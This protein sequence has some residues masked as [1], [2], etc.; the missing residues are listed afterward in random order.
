VTCSCLQCIESLRQQ[1]KA[2]NAHPPFAETEFCCSDCE[3]DKESLL[4]MH[5][6]RDLVN[7]C[8]CG[9]IYGKVDGST[10]CQTCSLKPV[11]VA[12]H[13]DPRRCISSEDPEMSH[14]TTPTTNNAFHSKIY[15]GRCRSGRSERNPN[16][17][18]LWV[19]GRF[20]GGVGAIW[21]ASEPL[22]TNGAS[23]VMSVG[24][25]QLFDMNNSSLR[26]WAHTGQQ[27]LEAT[28][29]TIQVYNF[30]T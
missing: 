26:F 27:L 25:L 5:N 1:S 19:A 3:R 7:P 22:R 21:R 10:T 24:S 12:N 29:I 14:Q 2:W 15:I 4:H 20:C 30:T 11:M 23:P 17:T 6:A 8:A 18:H 9:A 28:T 16:G 13:G